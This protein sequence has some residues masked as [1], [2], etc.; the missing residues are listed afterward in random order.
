VKSLDRG[1]DR[2]ARGK[3]HAHADRDA[4]RLVFDL[5]AQAVDCDTESLRVTSSAMLNCPAASV[6]APT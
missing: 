1:Q 5:S 4:K 2:K 6:C 3:H